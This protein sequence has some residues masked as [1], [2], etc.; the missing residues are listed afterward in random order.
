MSQTAPGQEPQCSESQTSSVELVI[1]SRPRDLGGFTV[2]RT[3]PAPK[4]RLVGP[5]VFFDHMGPAQI[6]P[7]AGFDVRPHPHIA[8]ATMTYLFDGEI[9]HRDSVGSVQAIQPG[10]VNWMV[11]GS[12]IVHSER[13]PTALRQSGF[14]IHG[15]QCWVALPLEA[16]ETEP[17]FAHHAKASIPALSRDGILLDVVAGTAF[18]QRSPVEV[19]SPTLYVHARLEAQATLT[20]EAEHEERALYVV[21]GA[22]SC[23]GQ[24]FEAGTLFVLRPGRSPSVT[25]LEASRVMLLGGAKLLGERHLWWNFVSSSKERIE[26][27]KQDWREDRFPKVP[28]DDERIP[29]PE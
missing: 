17:R 1:E 2:R 14:R 11:A 3:L 12:G 27:A 15:I 13:A 19:L 29:L 21:E 24:R 18:G 5:F 8:L 16:E 25:A 26:R 28:G 7:G 9:M 20:L 4:R 23:D 6:L 10:D 22:L